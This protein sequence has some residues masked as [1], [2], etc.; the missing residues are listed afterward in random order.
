[1]SIIFHHHDVNEV[2]KHKRKHKS[3]IKGIIE[4]NGRSVGDINYIF[5]SDDYLLEKN[6]SH[7]NH[8]TLTDIITFDLSEDKQII[9]ADIFISTDRVLDNSK[10]LGTLLED[11]L[12]RVLIHGIL[13]LFGMKDNSNSEK[14]KMRKAE[15]MA[16]ARFV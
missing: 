6:K 8:T 14:Q 2:L 13:H 9:S 12:R 5:C 3:W 10:L 11:E 15:D 16:M 7:L 1:M 4:S